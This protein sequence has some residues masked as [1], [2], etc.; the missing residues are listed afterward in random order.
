M[1]F[2]VLTLFPE[3]FSA[4]LVGG[5]VKR[6]VERN[7]ISIHANDIRDFATDRHGTVDD[8]PYGGGC[9]MVMKPEPLAG[10][11]RHAKEQYPEAHTLLLTPQGRLFNQGVAHEL[12]QCNGLIMI[13]G[14]YEGVDERICE[15]LIDEELS[16][17]DYVLTG[18]EL[19]AMVVI[20]AVSRLIPGVLG[21]TESAAEDSFSEGLLE[22]PQY[23]RPSSFEGVAVPGV[24]LSGNHQAIGRWRREASLLRT[25]VKRP[26][27]LLEH[28]MTSGDME[29]LKRLQQ[30][31]QAII[32]KHSTTC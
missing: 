18:G 2:T 13:C 14:R 11:I 21:N 23:T 7:C 3:M 25:F 12:A 10:A 6:S 30:D 5:M 28:S 16:V 19:A 17:G 22:Y 4:L 8:R 9:G 27:L 24:L 31:I 1:N 20:D 29:F 26:D 32:E 15:D